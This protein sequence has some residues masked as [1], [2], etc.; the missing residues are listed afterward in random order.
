MRWGLAM[1]AGMVVLFAAAGC[2]GSDSADD[3]GSSS[4]GNE[5]STAFSAYVDCLREQGIEV[6]DTMPTGGTRPDGSGRP[7]GMPSGMPTDRPSGT[8]SPGASGGPGGPGGQGGRPGGGG[9]GNLRPEGVDDET[10]QQAQ[11]ACQS[12][13]PTDRPDRNSEGGGPDGAE[14]GSAAAY[15]N[16]LADRD[17]Q[18]V[19]D[20]DSTDVK[21]TEALTACQPLSPSPSAG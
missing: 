2:G 1:A 5:Q 16:C 20:L 19:A 11:Q 13:L 12:V 9:F 6:S 3:T 10:W 8:P 14:Q 7:S 15:A 18:L 17:V 21:V 4:E